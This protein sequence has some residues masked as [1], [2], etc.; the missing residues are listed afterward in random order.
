MAVQTVQAVQVYQ[1]TD[2]PDDICMQ[3]LPFDSHF[4]VAQPLYRDGKHH[5]YYSN[6]HLLILLSSNMRPLPV[7]MYKHR[8]MT[9]DS[10]HEPH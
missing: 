9:L 5:G 4:N 7:D 2:E 3:I 1:S 6:R 8:Y 10:L